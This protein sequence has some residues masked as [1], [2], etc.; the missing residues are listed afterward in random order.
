VYVIGN[1]GNTADVS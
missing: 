1:D